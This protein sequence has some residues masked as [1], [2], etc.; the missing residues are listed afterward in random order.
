M[1][2]AGKAKPTE[3]GNDLKKFIL[4]VLIVIIKCYSTHDRR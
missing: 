1:W 3:S 2:H 4:N